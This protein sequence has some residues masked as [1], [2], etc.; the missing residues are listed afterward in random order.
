MAGSRSLLAGTLSETTPAIKIVREYDDIT[1][2]IHEYKM[3]IEDG[4]ED[5]IEDNVIIALLDFANVIMEMKERGVN[6]P[7]T[8]QAESEPEEEKPVKEDKPSEDGGN[9]ISYEEFLSN[10]GA[11]DVETQMK[12]G[13][14][15]TVVLDFS[16]GNNNKSDS[17]GT[18]Y[19]NADPIEELDYILKNGPRYGYHLLL[20]CNGYAE[21]SQMRFSADLFKHKILAGISKDDASMLVGAKEARA[22]ISLQENL[23]RY[24]NGV[25]GTTYKPY[26]FAGISFS[27]TTDDGGLNDIDDYFD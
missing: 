27:N 15:K 22:I 23:F 14:F 16:K 13:I 8:V 24:T 12:T 21:W 26:T 18:D 20:H 5:G 11:M 3:R 25:D 9:A 17:S 10:P 19:E 4:I 7:A 1:R 2:K 6:K